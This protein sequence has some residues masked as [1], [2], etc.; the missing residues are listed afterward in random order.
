[1][2]TASPTI[3]QTGSPRTKSPEDSSSQPSPALHAY[4]VFVACATFL[5]VTAG[6]WV[7][8]TGSSL[9]VPDWPLS[10]GQF[11]PKMEGGVLY[12]H[13][14]R[15]IAGTVAL[16][17]FL[18]AG[19]AWRSAVSKA[20]RYTALGACLA[21]ILQALLGG[22]TVLYRLPVPISVGHAF[23]GQTFFCFT[24][25]LA[26]LTAEPAVLPAESVQKIHR[27]GVLTLCFIFLQLIAGAIVRNTG[28]G[29]PVHFT[30]AALVIIHV[31]LLSRRVLM[32]V[33]L[34]SG[35]G[36]WAAALPVLV[37]L[38]AVLGFITWRTGPVGTA[39]AH[40]SIG[41]LIL[42]ANFLIT[43][44]AYRNKVLLR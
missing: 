32:A 40:V 5:L 39:T 43:L 7:K 1:M 41:A 4:A 26:V 8:S 38:Q 37:I 14:H 21:V 18:F 13:G 24:I 19:W 22:I 3:A 34:R 31:M 28:Q 12:E 17:T 33:P 10:F 6:A 27:L 15:M 30:G 29:M 23:L 25:A 2:N 42:A 9:A 44:Q 20:I 16:L 11:F 35:L 36:R